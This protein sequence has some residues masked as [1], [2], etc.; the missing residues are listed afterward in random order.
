M[1]HN[2]T[3]GLLA[4]TA[5][6]ATAPAAAGTIDFTGTMTTSGPGNTPG[7]AP[8][9][10]P[11]G[12]VRYGDGVG[13]IGLADGHSNIGAFEPVQQH[14]TSPPIPGVVPTTRTV[15]LGQFTWDFGGGDILRGTYDGF[16]LGD[17]P[18]LNIL[19]TYAV[20]GGEG[21]FRHA[22]G[23]IAA[24]AD[25]RPGPVFTTSWDFV[26]T[27]ETPAPAVAVLFGLGALGVLAGPRRC[28]G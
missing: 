28:L 14:C 21:R 9:F 8:C 16:T 18:V 5:A 12:L 19:A 26:G 2:V 4:A 3:L 6:L 25:V 15:T 20:D 13:G 22:T 10:A 11:L 24:D 1:R 23:T 7:A 27:I 17:P